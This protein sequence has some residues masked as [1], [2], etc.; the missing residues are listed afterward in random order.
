MDPSMLVTPVVCSHPFDRGQ[1]PKNGDV[2]IWQAWLD[3]P[4]EVVEM[5]LTVLSPDERRKAGRFYFRRDHDRYIVG[6]GLLRI[7]ISGYL[8]IEPGQLRFRYNFYGKPSLAA[9][10][11]ATSIK[12]NLSHSHGLAV[13]AVA[14]GREIGVDLEMIR[15]NFATME[16]AEQF[17][18]AR[19]VAALQTLSPELR[20]PAFFNCWTRKEAYI[21]ARGEG[22]SF[23]LDCFDVSLIPG[24]PAC[25][26]NVDGAADE[27][28][29]WSFCELDL[30]K[31]YV[32]SL[33]IQT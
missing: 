22:L 12:F 14:C 21:K 5:L 3:Q 7:I 26:L 4:Q 13:F 29:R 9:E 33:A 16:I 31:G 18:S 25:L 20:T 24:E 8:K 11:D 23:P 32:G 30:G 2:R 19:E 1:L 15:D 28:L 17:F 6:R 27:A 10:F